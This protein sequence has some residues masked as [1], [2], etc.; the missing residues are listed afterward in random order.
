MLRYLVVAN[1]TLGGE[2]L[3]ARVREC[4]A[5]EP[6]S[7]HIVVPATPPRDHLLPTEDEAREVAKGRLDQAMARFRELGADVDGEVGD[8]DPVQ[9]IG[10]AIRQ[11]SFDEI[12]LSTLPAGPSRWLRR[13]VP[14]RVEKAF[15][16]PVTHV[17]GDPVE[18]PSGSAS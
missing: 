1:Q 12:I 15:R 14:H 6:A 13:D 4:L 7:F 18:E 11:S 16:L 5:S 3:M 10:D 2:A 8:A 17:V 9:A